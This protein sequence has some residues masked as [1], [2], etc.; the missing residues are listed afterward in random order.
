MMVTARPG[1]KSR[2]V[3]PG[4]LD[5]LTNLDDFADATGIELPSGPYTTVAGFLMARLGRLPVVGDE[6]RIE[7]ATVTVAELDGRRVSRVGLQ[8]A[9]PDPV[10]ATNQNGATTTDRAGSHPAAAINGR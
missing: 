8:R 10:A 7:D 3:S 2:L 6:V 4:E 9:A 5:G 1:E